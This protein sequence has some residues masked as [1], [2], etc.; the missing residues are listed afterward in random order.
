M[1]NENLIPQT[2]TVYELKE[3]YKVPSFEEFMKTYELSEE[4]EILAETEYQDQVLNGSQYGP[5]KSDFK[6]LCR[7][8]KSA[9]SSYGKITAKISCESDPYKGDGYNYAGA[10][11]YAINGDFS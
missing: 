9:L 2:E 1:I 4:A 6:G 3:E 7:R 11:I 10:I 8:I 5:G